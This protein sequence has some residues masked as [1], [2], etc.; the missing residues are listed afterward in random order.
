MLC[1]HVMCPAKGLCT[2]SKEYPGLVPRKG[3][4]G[5]CQ[6]AQKLLEPL[7]A[8]GHGLPHVTPHL[9]CKYFSGF[10]LLGLP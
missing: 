7:L 3:L 6:V 5:R 9:T 4:A 8:H 2:G 10:S 1:V